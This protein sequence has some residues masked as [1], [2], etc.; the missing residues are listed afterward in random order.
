M[1]VDGYFNCSKKIEAAIQDV[2]GAADIIVEESRDG[3][4]NEN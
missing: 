3:C 2:E 4:L 1:I